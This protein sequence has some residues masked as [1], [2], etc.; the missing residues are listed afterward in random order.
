MGT[1]PCP[2]CGLVE[3]GGAC[4]RGGCPA[5]GTDAGR[6]TVRNDQDDD[7]FG[8]GEAGLGGID[9]LEAAE[10]PP[11]ELDHG[12]RGDGDDGAVAARA[13][14]LAAAKDQAA[15]AEVSGFG[16]PAA[17]P[18]GALLYC[19]H[20]LFRRRA[21]VGE[22]AA[23]A[24]EL[25][26]VRRQVADA[27]SGFARTLVAEAHRKEMAPLADEVGALY[28]SVQRGAS[29]KRLPP[30]AAQEVLRLREAVRARLRRARESLRPTGPG[31]LPD[32][33]RLSFPDEL[34]GASPGAV[35]ASSWLDESE[36]GPGFTP[37]D[38]PPSGDPVRDLAQSLRRFARR[39]SQA[40]VPGVAQAAEQARESVQRLA[41]RERMDALYALAPGTV[42]QAAFDRGWTLLAAAF[43]LVGAMLLAILLLLA[44][45][46]FRSG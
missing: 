39:A 13:Q 35:G 38:R 31:S 23:N 42:D 11:L 18:I 1:F 3:D 40:G 14:A 17:G 44:F 36:S 45:S 12:S 26:Q 4:A 25:E 6:T 43:G 16:A 22:A 27:L 29:A 10:A 34:L 7:L 41:Q 28:A 21:L 37:S 8:F 46:S 33:G 5:G 32:D 19:V 15:A 2:L 9:E 24:A 30:E 20:V